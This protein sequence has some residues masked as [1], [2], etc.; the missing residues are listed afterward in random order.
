MEKI[1][2][3]CKSYKNDLKY[4]KILLD[5]IQK[6]NKDNIPVI[7]SCPL[8]DI[9]LFVEELKPYEV[10]IIND[11]LCC[12]SKLTG[13]GWLDQQ[14]VKANFWRID[15]AE[16]WLVLD[17]DSE[18]I[19]DFYKDDFMV[20]NEI[21]YT[22]MHEQ[23]QLFL[24]S[25]LNKNKLGFDPKKSFKED[26][27]KIMKAF[28]FENLKTIYDFGPSPVIWNI[29]VWKGLNN[30]LNENGLTIEDALKI[31]SSEFSWYGFFLLYS[32]LFPIFPK[33]PLF[34]VYHYKEQFDE[35]SALG[36]T[37]EILKENYLGVIHQS[38]W[39]QIN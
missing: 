13:N 9:N 16:N 12:V 39:K 24:W 27:I 14:I 15:P 10:Q 30:I 2:L 20:D 3:Y 33:E 5:S 11:E 23:K 6:F 29:K 17:S 8:P 18:F 32:K 34:F 28:E 25:S 37:N 36:Y 35:H 26:R 21:P 19:R 4:L 7:I 38:N 31:V 1:I 22:V